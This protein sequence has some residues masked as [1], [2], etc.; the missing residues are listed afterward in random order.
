MWSEIGWAGHE[1]VSSNRLT[2]DYLSRTS[3]DRILFGSRG[4]P[5]R[6]GSRIDAAFD[7]DADVSRSISETLFDWFPM[8][9]GR[10]NITHAW[11][12]PVGMPRDWMPTASFNPRSGIATARGY[13][14]QG[15]A[16]SN[17]AGRIL[18][19]LI[20]G[21]ESD[22]TRLPMANHRARS[23]EPE[24]LRW[25]AVRYIQNRLQRVDEKAERT[26]RPP[27]GTSLAERLA[28]H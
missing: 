27:K 24:P 14:G 28:R 25:L 20:T 2:V 13:T 1:G 18:A 26:G 23:W 3:D 4:A 22:L 11:A 15:V 12:G 17:L 5:Y 10:V 19:D 6:F 9:R 7:H 16:I 21:V 8:M